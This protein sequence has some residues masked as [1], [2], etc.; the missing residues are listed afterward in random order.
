[1]RRGCLPLLQLLRDRTPRPR[2]VR[3]NADGSGKTDITVDGSR[4][5]DQPFCKAAFAHGPVVGQHDGGRT[6]LRRLFG[7][8]GGT[9]RG[10]DSLESSWLC[11]GNCSD[12][13]SVCVD[14]FSRVRSDFAGVYFYDFGDGLFGPGTCGRTLII[15]NES[16]GIMR[17]QCEPGCSVF[18]NHLLTANS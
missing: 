4:R 14:Y 8:D 9:V 3:E 17:W 15:H 18:G 10:T 7:I 16:F 11:L 6:D 13:N 12:W 1:M 5:N 2:G